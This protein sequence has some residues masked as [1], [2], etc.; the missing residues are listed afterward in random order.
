MVITTIDTIN[1]IRN[2]VRATKVPRIGELIGLVV[3]LVEGDVN[4]SVV[5]GMVVC[6]VER[7]VRAVKESWY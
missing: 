3:I 1:P 2:V 4:I 6:V 5:V 7:G